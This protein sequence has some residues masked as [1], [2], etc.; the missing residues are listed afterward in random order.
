MTKNADLLVFL[1]TLVSF[2][3]AYPHA[4]GMFKGKRTQPAQEVQPYGTAR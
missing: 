2:V 4:H 1:H 3:I